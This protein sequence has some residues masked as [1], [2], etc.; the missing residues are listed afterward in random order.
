MIFASLLIAMAQVDAEIDPLSAEPSVEIVRICGLIPDGLAAVDVFRGGRWMRKGGWHAADG[1]GVTAYKTEDFDE[2]GVPEIV[3]MGGQIYS[4]KKE[5]EILVL[6]GETG[7]VLG[8]LSP[9]NKN[10]TFSQMIP[11][12]RAGV[13]G[14]PANSD[15]LLIVGTGDWNALIEKIHL[16]FNGGKVLLERVL[17]VGEQVLVL[18]GLCFLP[19]AQV[20]FR[21]VALDP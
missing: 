15:F 13:G 11:F 20:G 1:R 18:Q 6:T 19:G 16:E 5:G 7:K 8:Q 21:V 4:G 17:M 12:P 2:D 9:R 3:L 10:S 14:Y